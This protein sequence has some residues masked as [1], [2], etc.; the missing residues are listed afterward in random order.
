MY[1]QPM[2]GFRNVPLSIITEIL[3]KKI[4]QKFRLEGKLFRREKKVFFIRIY[5][6]W[7]LT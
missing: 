2:D 4:N 1:S 5:V 7:S 3:G 6:F